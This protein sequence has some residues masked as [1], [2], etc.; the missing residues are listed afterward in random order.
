MKKFLGVL[1]AVVAASVLSAC[2]NNSTNSITNPPTC[3][4]Q[5]TTVM[6]YPINGATNVPVTA[7]TVYIASNN[8]T[9]ANG[10]FGTVIQPPNGLPYYPGSP[11][12]QVPLSSVPKPHANPS[13]S[14]PSYYASGIGGLSAGSTYTIGFNVINQVCNPAGIGV[15]TTQ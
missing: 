11:F 10:N 12:T 6:I 15:F 7:N 2:N 1:I 5:G 4:L 14:N 13:I 8:N 3:G 9:L